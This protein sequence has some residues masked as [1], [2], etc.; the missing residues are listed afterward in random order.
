MVERNFAIRLSVEQS[1]QVRRELQSLGKDGQRALAL[2]ES[3]GAQA[4][5]G[6]LAVQAGGRE[7]QGGLSAMAGRAGPA[8]A[9]LAALGPA[10]LAAAAGIGGLFIATRRALDGAEQALETA[11][12]LADTAD[13]I[14]VGIEALQEYR[15][16]AEQSGVATQQFEVAL[17]ALIRRQG[18]A[19]NGN[20]EF[21]KGFEQV[22]IGIKE[23]RQLT[24]EQLVARVA[25]GLSKI[26]SQ[27]LRVAAADRIMSEAGRQVINVFNDGAAGLQRFAAE[28][29]EAGIVI[30]AHLARNARATKNELEL[31]RSVIDAQLTTA[32]VSLGPVLVDI[33]GFF[34]EVAQAVADV[35]DS[36]RDLEDISTRGLERRVAELREEL[37]AFEGGPKGS[38]FAGRANEEQKKRDELARALAEL[39]RRELAR[40]GDRPAATA[41]GAG[42]I[43]V[44][45]A[46]Q[47]KLTEI[48]NRRLAAE[49]E[50][51]QVL[52]RL[53]GA[54]SVVAEARFKQAEATAAQDK[55]LRAALESL[56]TEVD[57]LALSESERAAVV[58]ITEIETQAKRKLTEAEKAQ[59]RALTDQL[60]ATNRLK[61]GARDLGLTFSSALGD[62]IVQGEGL[63]GVLQ[64]IERDILKILAK[65]AVTDPL[66]DA[67]GGF[68]YGS[69]FSAVFSSFLGAGAGAG[70]SS[71]AASGAGGFRFS[72]S[73]GLAEGGP[74]QGGRP[75]IVGERGPEIFVPRHSGT[76]IPNDRL[77]G[78]TVNVINNAGAQ[79]EVRENR[80]STGGPSI[81]IMIDKAVAQAVRGRG[82]ETSRALSETFGAN[83]RL[84][85]R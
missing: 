52:E 9:A 12:A 8:G 25:D 26:E 63:R 11:T 55:A 18:E 23:L 15:F 28:A 66:S 78:V 6:L 20:K 58:K 32:L 44:E 30:D 61:D 65:R 48:G 38:R 45:I 68:D 59:V 81:E 17:T 1:A 43:E 39:R 71:L 70:G 10:G 76:V 41:A 7:L 24:P 80:D 50:S 14:G 34:A 56:K 60:S 16:A 77:G 21:A 62:A 22:G 82:S 54:E 72:G 40:G 79:V 64:G 29:R 47:E 31:M 84:A 37:A 69:I 49:R 2:I 46:R 74:A 27:A 53:G 75:Y 36:F 13:R 35:V 4:Q 42:A 51:L 73:P 83:R 57:L 33:A 67:I 3:G 5:R 19:I 85:L